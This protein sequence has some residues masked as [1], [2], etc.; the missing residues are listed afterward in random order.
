MKIKNETPSEDNIEVIFDIYKTSLIKHPYLNP[1]N[2]YRR[3]LNLGL[4]I[5]LLC[6]KDRGYV[7]YISPKFLFN[8]YLLPGITDSLESYV[9]LYSFLKKEFLYTVSNTIHFYINSEEVLE[10]YTKEFRSLNHDTFEDVVYDSNVK[11][12]KAKRNRIH[13]NLKKAIQNGVKV[14][15]VQH[16]ESDSFREWYDNCYTYAYDNRPPFTYTQLYE[17]TQY[18]L[19]QYLEKFIIAEVDGKILG[20]IGILM[21][22]YSNIAW[23]NWGA[24]CKEGREKG[25]GYVLMEKAI[26][27]VTE[28]GKIFELYGKSKSDRDPKHV[29]IFEFKKVFGQEVKIPYYSSNNFVEKL[30]RL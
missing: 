18:L 22:H 1:Y 21:D 3:K 8:T 25:A 11:L 6:F 20:G 28:K 23:Y 14:R 9:D 19:E 16:L 5:K 15:I 17:H 24:I 7:A 10:T 4:N 26:E 2:L 27:I 13:I 29:G 30:Y 12:N